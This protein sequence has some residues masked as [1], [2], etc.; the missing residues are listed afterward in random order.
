MRFDKWVS[1]TRGSNDR[2]LFATHS[3]RLAF[4]EMKK[5]GEKSNLQQVHLHKDLIRRGQLCVV[6]DNFEDFVA[7]C[8]HLEAGT[9]PMSTGAGVFDG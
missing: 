3:G 1:G 4:V 2:I 5:A 9:G 8:D 6:V 7:L